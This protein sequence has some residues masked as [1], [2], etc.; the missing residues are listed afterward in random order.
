MTRIEEQRRYMPEVILSVQPIRTY[1]Y[2]EL[3]V[4]AFRL[5]W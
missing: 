2:H 5:C 3:A 1:P 4:H